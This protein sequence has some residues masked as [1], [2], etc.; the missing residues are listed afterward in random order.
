MFWSV[1]SNLYNVEELV[2]NTQKMLLKVNTNQ[3]HIREDDLALAREALHHTYVVWSH[4]L[5]M[6]SD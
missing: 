6:S 2:E 5:M 3:K 1:D 4:L